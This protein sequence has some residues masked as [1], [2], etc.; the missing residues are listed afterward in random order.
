MVYFWWK[1]R[2]HKVFNCMLFAWFSAVGFLFCAPSLLWRGKMILAALSFLG[3]SYT[4]LIFPASTCI[5]ARK[6]PSFV[7]G[8]WAQKILQTEGSCSN[9]AWRLPV[10][11]A[12]RFWWYHAALLGYSS[13]LWHTA[14]WHRIHAV[15]HVVKQLW[16]GHVGNGWKWLHFFGMKINEIG[17]ERSSCRWQMN[18]LRNEIS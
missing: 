14:T 8:F 10:T 3:L 1:K 9:P 4:L 12:H 6:Y 2:R 18:S 7:L 15:K 11:P 17:K 16:L 5:G 13:C